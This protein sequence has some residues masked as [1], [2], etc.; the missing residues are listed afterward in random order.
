MD[1]EMFQQLMSNEMFQSLA[2]SSALSDQ[3]MQQAMA[4]SIPQ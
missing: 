1:N 2:Q 3:F 4:I